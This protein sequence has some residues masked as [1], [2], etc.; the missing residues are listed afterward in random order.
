MSNKSNLV[1]NLEE[2]ERG[3]F[4]GNFI[5]TAFKTDV[6]EVAV[7]K[8]D[9]GASEESHF[10]KIATEITLIL[11]GQVQMLGRTFKEGDI[12]VVEPGV[13]TAFEAL[14]DCV[15]VVVKIPGATDDK[16]LG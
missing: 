11:E 9:R 2:M 15:N 3:W 8:Y 13:R 6:C 1:A 16:Y 12:I 14:T 4:V 10:H 5:P 7:K